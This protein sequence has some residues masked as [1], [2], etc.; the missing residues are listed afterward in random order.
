[1]RTQ[2]RG[3]DLIAVMPLPLPLDFGSQRLVWSGFRLDSRAKLTVRA[4]LSLIKLLAA[5]L[6][7]QSMAVVLVLLRGTKARQSGGLLWE[8]KMHVRTRCS[9]LCNNVTAWGHSNV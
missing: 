5:E 2:L 3:S 9:R 6:L 8:H 1:M 7:G 4:I